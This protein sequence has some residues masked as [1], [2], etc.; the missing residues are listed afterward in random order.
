MTTSDSGIAFI[1][2][3]EGLKLTA[4]RDSGGVLTIGYGHTGG[5]HEAETI[6]EAQA[7]AFLAQDLIPAENAANAHVKVPMTQNQFDALVDFTFNLG[8]GAFEGSH[9]LKFLN[10]GDKMGAAN[11]FSK[12]N[13]INGVVSSGLLRRRLA[14]RDLFLTT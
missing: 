5:L 7:E 6:T 3:F 1:K 14:E 12:W 4:Y 11:E 8:I 2:S 9:L 13:H 10:A